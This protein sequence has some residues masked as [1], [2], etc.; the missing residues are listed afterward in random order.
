M[1]IERF[2]AALALLGVLA[3]CTGA[4]TSAG[5]E[6]AYELSA[7][8]VNYTLLLRAAG[9][10]SLS[11]S[12]KAIGDLRWALD[13]TPDQQTVELNAGGPVYAALSSIVP[14][15]GG[16]PSPIVATSGTLGPAPECTRN[17]RMTKHVLNFDAGIAFRRSG[18]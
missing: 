9:T 3:G 1:M 14:R 7:K 2:A 13:N 11:I 8:G 15:H 5:V 16:P 6:G 17:G 12:G 10:G 4:C 18:S